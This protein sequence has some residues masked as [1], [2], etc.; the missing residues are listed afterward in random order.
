MVTVRNAF[1]AESQAEVCAANVARYL[2]LSTTTASS[3]SSSLPQYSTGG[4]IKYPQGLF[5]VK[6]CPLLACVSLGE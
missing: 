4:M 3:S 2:S 6:E 5:G 1:L